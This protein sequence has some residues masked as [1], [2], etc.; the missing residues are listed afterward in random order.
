[1]SSDYVKNDKSTYL[2][3]TGTGRVSISM[4]G[5]SAVHFAYN[6]DL[7]IKNTLTSNMGLE[8]YAIMSNEEKV[9]NPRH[10]INACRNLR[11]KQKALSRKR[12]P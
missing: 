6:K 4:L 2:P 11:R 5:S 9:P 7:H 1:M 3:D 10:L 8:H 12:E